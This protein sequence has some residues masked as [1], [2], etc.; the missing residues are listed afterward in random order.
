MSEGVKPEL[1]H[2]KKTIYQKGKKKEG[3]PVPAR[4]KGLKPDKARGLAGNIS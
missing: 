1:I 4:P 2:Q 3:I